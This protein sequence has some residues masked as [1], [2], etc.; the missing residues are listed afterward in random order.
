MQVDY[1]IDESLDPHEVGFDE[2]SDAQD[3]LLY[4]LLLGD[5]RATRVHVTIRHLE[6]VLVLQVVVIAL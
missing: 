3:L 2:V 1:I 4:P 5:G 6:S